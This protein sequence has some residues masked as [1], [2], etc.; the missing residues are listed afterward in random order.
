MLQTEFSFT[1]PLGLVD[2]Q[3]NLHRDGVMRR[4][5]A[6]DE[7]EP[8]GDGRVKANPSWAAILLLS[9]VIS[10][11]GDITPVPPELVGRLFATDFTFLQDLYLR[12][13]A[14]A[15]TRLDVSCP[16]CATTFSVTGG[17]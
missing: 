12:V 10:R 7:V 3:G 1:L 11:I 14:N 17:L 16:T 5:T 2:E 15:G 4:A 6:L 13:N 9:R 8:A